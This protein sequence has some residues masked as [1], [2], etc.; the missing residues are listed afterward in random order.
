MDR[1]RWSG[2]EAYERFM[3]RWSRLLADRVISDQ[4]VRPGLRWLDVGCGTG[5]LTQSVLTHCS[6][7]SVLGVDPAAG[8]VA[9]AR[10]QVTDARASFE[11]GSAERLPL[12][13]GDVDRVVSGLVLNFVPDQEM[14]LTEMRRV[15]RP[16]GAATVYVW[17]YADGMQ[18]LRYFW[19]AAAELDPGSAIHDEGDRFPVCQTGGLEGALAAVGFSDIRAGEAWIPQVF[20]DFDDYWQ[21]FLGGTGPASAYCAS[22]TDPGRAR[23]A[24]RLVDRLPTQSDGSIRLRAR[25]WVAT[26]VSP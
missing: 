5:A 15:L 3:G 13:D 12:G 17:D 6:P 1:D 14:A 24:E 11:T 9:A 8:F 4:T 20:A 18:M 21:P 26:A 23:L 16:G 22:L 10:E 25:A 7:Q 2:A 19:D